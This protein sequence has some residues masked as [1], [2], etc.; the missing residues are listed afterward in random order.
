MSFI[1]FISSD[2][3]A[4]APHT[5]CDTYKLH[6]E[7]E[8]FQHRNTEVSLQHRGGGTILKVCGPGLKKLMSGG[9]G[10][11]TPTHFFFW[12]SNFFDIYF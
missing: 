11:G 12:T 5:V 8:H 10:G 9:G 7:E 6:F 2:G 4:I 3:N 1:K